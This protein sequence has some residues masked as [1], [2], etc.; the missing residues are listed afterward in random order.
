MITN[1]RDYIHITYVHIIIYRQRCVWT[2]AEVGR[3][4]IRWITWTWNGI[5]A[6]STYWYGTTKV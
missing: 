4:K 1:T 6:S 2:L 5:S 3:I